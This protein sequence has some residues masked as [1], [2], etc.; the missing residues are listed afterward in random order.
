[1]G[2]YIKKVENLRK[3]LD[4]VSYTMT[5]VQVRLE[6]LQDAITRQEKAR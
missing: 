1:V 2:P 4:T 5:R 3:R 6:S